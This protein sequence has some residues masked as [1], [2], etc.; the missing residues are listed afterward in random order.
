MYKVITIGDK[1]I[2]MLAA[3]SVN[4]FCKRIFGIDPLK[5]VGQDMDYTDGID[6]YQKVGFVMAKLA[7]C[8]KSGSF[9]QM[10][11]LNEDSY[12]MWLCD[13]DNGDFIEKTRDI[14]ELYIGANKPTEKPKNR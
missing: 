5:T 2:P 13:I 14:A 4:I 3:A 1:E 8:N 12:L 6:L 11:E 7:E 10:N 9:A